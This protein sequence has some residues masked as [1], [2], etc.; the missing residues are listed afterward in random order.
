MHSVNFE[1]SYL[2]DKGSIKSAVDSSTFR[3]SVLTFSHN[4]SIFLNKSTVSKV[5]IDVS[6]L[7]ILEDVSEIHI[8]YIRVE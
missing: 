1:K 6:S 7:H 4:V 5:G 3:K 8:L 2:G